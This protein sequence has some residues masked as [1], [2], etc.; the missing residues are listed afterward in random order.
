MIPKQI[1]EWFQLQP[2]IAE[3]GYFAGTYQSATSV[4]VSDSTGSA[5]GEPLSI[6]SA[7]YYFLEAD[8]CSVIHKVATDMIYHFYS[9]D[10]VEMLLLYPANSVK[11]YEICFFSNDIAAGAHPMKIIPGGTWL[12]SRLTP[13]GSYSLMGVTMAPGFDP[14]EY[15]IGQR[16]DLIKEYPEAKSL[17][18]ELTREQNEHLRTASSKVAVSADTPG[19]NGIEVGADFRQEAFLSLSMYLTG[20]ERTELQGTGMLGEYYRRVNSATGREDLDNLWSIALRL[21]GLVKSKSKESDLSREIENALMEDAQ[22][23]PIARSIIKLW[24]RGD[25][26]DSTARFG[27]AFTSAQAYQEGLLWRA[28]RTHASG[29]KAPGFG[30]W[31]TPPTKGDPE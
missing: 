18:I 4:P 7:I 10:P 6:C 8:T 30:S 29:A 11:R 19:G 28:M 13:G 16:D 9:G 3:G 24:Y 15:A 21:D 12:G 20:F 23:G 26:P 22:L 5:K 1:I 31:S 2:N 14:K 25:W 17:I 27:T